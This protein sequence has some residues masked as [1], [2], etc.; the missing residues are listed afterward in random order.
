MIF[1]KSAAAQYTLNDFWEKMI[2][3]RTSSRNI[4]RNRS[5]TDV[6]NKQADHNMLWSQEKSGKQEEAPRNVFL[7]VINRR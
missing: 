2:F 1:L 3:H 7:S 6:F 5:G 4:G